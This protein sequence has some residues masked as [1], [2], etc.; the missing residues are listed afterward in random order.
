MG[1]ILKFLSHG[2]VA[3]LIATWIG[4]LIEY[5]VF[6]SANGSPITYEEEKPLPNRADSIQVSL[7]YLKISESESFFVQQDGIL[8]IT[9]KHKPTFEKEY[10]EVYSKLHIN[11]IFGFEIF[12]SPIIF[13]KQLKIITT[14][15][16]G[17]F[18]DIFE[19]DGAF[20]EAAFSSFVDNVLNKHNK[21]ISISKK[22]RN[23]STH[24]TIIV[25]TVVLF[26][27]FRINRAINNFTDS[28]FKGIE[29]IFK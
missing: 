11:S 15:S 29:S 17:K 26:L 27:I 22:E 14:T 5:N 10:E 23:T 13:K 12:Y 21:N 28:I 16:N 8:K 25:I 7:N 4:L 3:G 24:L 18:F 2:L 20:S 1:S 9:K 6:Q 19:L